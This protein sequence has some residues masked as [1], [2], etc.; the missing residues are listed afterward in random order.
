MPSYHSQDPCSTAIVPLE[1]TSHRDSGMQLT[2]SSK[3]SKHGHTC[4]FK[5]KIRHWGGECIGSVAVHTGP[6][7]TAEGQQTWKTTKERGSWKRRHLEDG[8]TR[9]ASCPPS[10]MSHRAAFSPCCTTPL[11]SGSEKPGPFRRKASGKLQL[12]EAGFSPPG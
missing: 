4:S 3:G 8:G 12:S 1:A 6:S 2:N 7:I 11:Q 9:V 10:P 5:C